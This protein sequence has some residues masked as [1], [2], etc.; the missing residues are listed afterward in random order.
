[1]FTLLRSNKRVLAS[2]I[3]LTALAGC[4]GNEGNGDGKAADPAN[5][6][7]GSGKSG[8][9][10]EIVF[11]STN[12]D[13][14]ESFDY[15]F[16]DALRR[17]FPNYTIKYIQNVKGSSMQELLTA[18]TKFDIYFISTGNYE[19]ILQENGLQV[20][21]DDLVKK[22][23]VDLSRIEPTVIESIRQTS[24]GK[25][26][27]IPVHTNNMVLYYNKAIFDK[28]GVPYPKEGMTWDQLLETA[29]KLTVTDNGVRYTGF[30]TSANHI[31]RMNQLSIPNVDLKG[32]T[33]TINKDDRWQQF[34]QSVFL[35]PYSFADYRETITELKK[36]PD[37]NVFL[38]D[39]SLAMYAYLSSLVYVL[40]EDLKKLNWDMVPL[41]SF[42]GQPGV[43]SQ[44]Y[45][46]YF[47]ITKLSQNQDEAMEVLKYM[48]SEEFQ[49]ELAKKGI[50][51]VLK[52]EAVQKQ[53]GQ[54]SPF[55][56]KNFQAVFQNKFAPIPPKA[57]YDAGIVNIYAKY[58]DQVMKQ[59]TD[60]NTALRMAEEEAAK[61]IADY[62]NK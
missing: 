43:G 26:Y 58:A 18:G 35:K 62:K 29:Q 32:E 39:Q 12:G 5:Q 41:P 34:F 55:K 57:I 54:D 60:L 25:L 46:F 3:A 9:P 15:R 6:D 19:Q 59:T 38:K 44:S 8:K 52:N 4:A 42:N 14:V 45:P 40:P 10:V 13:P 49:T 37:M 17:K 30:S 56:D 24:G 21:M 31:L 36:V 51:P 27:G 33:P 7:Q 11:Y 22:H 20:D 50:M 2:I 1:M 23:N 53:L 16:G 61:Y 47:G 48:I 28:F